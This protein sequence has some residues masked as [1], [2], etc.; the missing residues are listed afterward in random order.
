M[1][2]LDG[3]TQNSFIVLLQGEELGFSQELQPDGN[4]KGK[5]KLLTEP[6]VHI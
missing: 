1:L 3:D 5:K 4:F 2:H 6:F